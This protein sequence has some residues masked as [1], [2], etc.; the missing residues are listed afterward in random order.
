VSTVFI[1]ATGTDLGK[2]FVTCR[3]LRELA[4]AGYR[5][6]A[7]KPVL[8]GFDA[9]DAAGSDT[10]RILHAQGLALSSRNI[11]S[12]S[13]WRFAAP[14]SPHMAAKREHRRVPYDSL[15]E[16]C[17]PRRD[18][19]MTL[20]EG[21]GGVMA[22]I[23]DE[24]TVLD[25]MQALDVPVLLVVGSYLGTLSHALTAA[26]MLADH[27]IDLAGVI[28]SESIAQTVTLAETAQ[29]LQHFLPNTIVAEL[30][31]QAET[32]DPRAS[33]SLPALLPLLSPYLPRVN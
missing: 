3:L 2:T 19:D 5:H 18:I 31:R 29:T 17:R 7:L 11:E 10:G 1:S 26:G 30:P 24:H 13:P 20:I 4:A 8:S 14:L 27:G 33:T 22:P 12:V 15:I 23:D 28:V 16:F 21:V 32:S 9:D 6:R 25:W